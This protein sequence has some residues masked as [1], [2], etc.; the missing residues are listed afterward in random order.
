MGPRLHQLVELLEVRDCHWPC[1]DLGVCQLSACRCI[2][3]QAA[4][5][6]A[7]VASPLPVVRHGP[8][9]LPAYLCDTQERQYGCD[10][11][12]DMQDSEQAG[13]GGSGFSGGYTE[14]ELLARVQCSPGELQAALRDRH[15]LCLGELCW[16]DARRDEGVGGQK[17]VWCGMPPSQCVPSH[18]LAPAWSIP[19]APHAAILHAGLHC[20]T[21]DAGHRKSTVPQ[22]LLLV[23][24]QCPAALLTDARYCTVDAGYQGMLLELVLLTAVEHGWPLSALPGAKVAA[25]LE[26]HGYDPRCVWRPK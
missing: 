3:Q 21:V 14:A 25:A 9:C 11:D 26:P 10:A 8:P 20:C 22:L 17:P 18:V 7:A 16:M 13:S 1:C 12:Q 6:S 24:Q 23:I 15:A 2:G 19:S 5:D 4:G